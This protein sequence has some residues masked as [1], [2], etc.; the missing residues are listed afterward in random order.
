MVKKRLVVVADIICDE[1]FS[2]TNLILCEDLNFY[3]INADEAVY[4]GTGTAE[5]GNMWELVDYVVCIEETLS[6][7]V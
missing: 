5:T 7:E 1:D 4:V 2:T 6:E 3:S